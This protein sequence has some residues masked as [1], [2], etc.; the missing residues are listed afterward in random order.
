MS[1]GRKILVVDD[2]T[3]LCDS[4]KDILSIDGYVVETVENGSEAIGLCGNNTYDIAII[5]I[6]LPDISG[7]KVVEEIA[8]LSPLTEFIYM[9]GQATID[10]A[11]EAVKQKNV[12]SYETKPLDMER[13]HTLIKQVVER[14]HIDNKLSESEEALQRSNSLLSSIIE[15]PDNIIIFA[16]DTNY[17]YLNFNMAHV[18]RMKEAYNVDIEIGRNILT[19]ISVEDDRLQAEENFKRVL[20][21]ER[22]VKIEE[23]GHTGNRG[24]YELV[25][26][27]IYDNNDVT[28]FTVFVIDITERKQMEEAL[29]QSEKLKSIGTITAGISHEFNNIL[30]IISGKVQLL[31]MDYED[32]K[33]LKDELRIIMNAADDGAEISSK[34]LQ[35]TKTRQDRDEFVPSDITDLII[36]SINFTRPRWINEAQAKGINYQIDRAGMARVPFIKCNPT[37]IREVFVNIINNALDAMPGGG[38]ITFSTSSN[39][40]AFFVD[41][42]DTGE[43]MT[44]DV[45]KN[46]FDPFFTTKTPEGTGLGMSM[47]YGIITRHGGKIEVQSEPGKGSKF[48]IQFPIDAKTVSTV[49]KLEPQQETI[50]KNLHILVVD[51]EEDIRNILDQLLSRDG[52]KVKTVDNGAD[53]IKMAEGEDFDLVLCDLAMPNIFGY[54]VVRVLNGLKK[55]PKIGIITGW[56]DEPALASGKELKVDF[57]LQKPFKHSVLFKHINELF[58]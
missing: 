4:L 21:G 1:I 32:N 48:S 20:R 29:L 38:S 39:D 33:E 24:W 23:Y 17:N 41:I 37:E 51:D 5:D 27:P 18:K 11:I 3:G 54:D 2:N 7:I 25:L 50:E 46:V 30:S 36:E 40:D 44:E 49:S 31:E 58:I 53:A 15:S 43:G 55:R 57:Y 6:S 26:N 13:F 10:S 28:G 16:L 12:I 42:T 9:T 22:F 45:K 56:N 14:R 47:A 34:M 19:Y 52:H 8:R 35:F